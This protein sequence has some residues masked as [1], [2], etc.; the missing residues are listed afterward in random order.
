MAQ[1]AHAQP[2][3]TIHFDERALRSTPGLAALNTEHDLRH[4]LCTSVFL[5]DRKS[6]LFIS[7]FR[8]GSDARPFCQEDVNLKQLLTPHLYSCW[9]TNLHAEIE[10]TR[11]AQSA[12]DSASA[13]IDRK[14]RVIYA[15]AVF[16]ELIAERWPAW[17]GRDLPAQLLETISGSRK[18]AGNNA[19][20]LFVSQQYAGGLLRLDI[21]RP[22]L[23]DT[24]TNREREI[25]RGFAQGCSYK[26]IAILMKLSPATVR[27]YLRVI[28]EKLDINDKAEL[29][30][31]IDRHDVDAEFV[32]SGAPRHAN[33]SIDF[34]GNG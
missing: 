18:L 11:Q 32:Q 8:S 13:F 31:M 29:V 15:S 6:F 33:Q 7:L 27:H 4:A 10:R 19:M 28:Y 20:G 24:L 30:R 3:T 17:N 9:R 5:P 26:E 34:L 1:D 12:A 25:A 22:S 21:R 14:G 2:R 23:L 16:G